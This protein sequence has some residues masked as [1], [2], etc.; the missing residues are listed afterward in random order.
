M[1]SE[2]GFDAVSARITLRASQC[3]RK[4]LHHPGVGIHSR[5]GLPVL[6][7]PGAQQQSLCLK[8]GHGP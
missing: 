4:V 2:V 3:R 1:S 6:G 8:A 5:K 7:T